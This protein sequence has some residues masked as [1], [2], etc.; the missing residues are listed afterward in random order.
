MAWAPPDD[1]F[2]RL[3]APADAWFA[4]WT[5]QYQLTRDG[6]GRLAAGFTG[7]RVLAIREITRQS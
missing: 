7:L 1:A 3:A 6:D 5:M 2:G 4:L